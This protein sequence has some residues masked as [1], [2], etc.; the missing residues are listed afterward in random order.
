VFGI[1]VGLV[2]PG[3]W[4]IIT[5][6]VTAWNVGVWLYLIS[7]VWLFVRANH[8][9]VSAIAEMEDNSAAAVLSVLSIAA[10]ISLA[11]IILH[12]EQQRIYS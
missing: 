10:V 5:R 12:W 3:N 11:A 4:Q 9:K 6:A 2:L 1:L 7:I 8:T